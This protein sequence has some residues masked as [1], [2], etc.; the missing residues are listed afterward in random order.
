M[1]AVPPLTAVVRHVLPVAVAVAFLVSCRLAPSCKAAAAICI[2]C[3]LSNDHFHAAQA[4]LKFI[5]KISIVTRH[6]MVDHDQP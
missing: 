4:R 2:S 5:T 3:L 6:I 1:E